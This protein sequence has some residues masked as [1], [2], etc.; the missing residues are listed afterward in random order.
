MVKAT[1]LFMCLLGHIELFALSFAELRKTRCWRE[2]WPFGLARANA[3][4]RSR[5][6][7]NTLLSFFAL[8]YLRYR[9][10][11]FEKPMLARALTCISAPGTLA[12]ISCE[13]PDISVV[14]LRLLK[15]PLVSPD[16]R[17]GSA[18]GGWPVSS[19]HLSNGY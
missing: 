10:L 18:V 1:D 5:A 2:R 3:F 14:R 4:F 16:Q 15:L 12:D 17:C 8:R 11:S 7:L 13:W 19:S 9:S 6:Q